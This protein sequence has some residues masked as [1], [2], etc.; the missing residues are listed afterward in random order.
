MREKSKLFK[1]L[2]LTLLVSISVLPV[3]SYALEY[4]LSYGLE[5]LRRKAE[6]KKCGVINSD[7]SFSESD[8]EQVL[9]ADFEYLTITSLPDV[10][11]GALKIGGIDVLENQTISKKNISMLK[12]VPKADKLCTA[13]FSFRDVLN[14]NFE[15]VCTVNILESMNLSPQTA[16]KQI[17][18]Q[19]NISVFDFLQGADPEGDEIE[20]EI[21]SYPQNGIAQIQDSASGYFSYTPKKD[22]CGK[23]SLE[24]R[25]TDIYGNTSKTQS[26]DIRVEKTNGN[27]SFSDMQNHWAHNSAVKIASL[28][29]LGGDVVGG[30]RM[31]Y[32]EEP[33][34]KGDFLAMAMIATGYEPKVRFVSSTSFADDEDIP[35]NIKS[36]AAAAYEMGIISGV[37]REDGVYFESASNITRAQASVILEALVDAP[38]PVV[39]PVFADYEAIP[40]FAREAIKNLAFCKIINGNGTGNIDPAGIVTRA[41]TAQLLCNAREYL[42]EKD[43]KASLFNLFGLIK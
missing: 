25:V 4:D 17:E 12:F 10:E 20:F 22:F 2:A 38:E 26:L 9:G 42:E 35:N 24:Y 21:V 37:Q 28:G 18:T 1:I 3:L 39:S 43:K 5:I 23:D 33:V 32:P 41:Q 29:F 34:S 27:I 7:V 30:Q 19:K 11:Q 6:M 8:F 15:N 40:T 31:F 16:S 36:Y 14:E 13:T